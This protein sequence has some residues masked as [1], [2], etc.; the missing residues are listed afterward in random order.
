MGQ[1]IYLIS[2]VVYGKCMFCF[3][4]GRMIKTDDKEKK[5][6]ALLPLNKRVMH[7]FPS[8]MKTGAPKKMQLI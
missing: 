2:C 3:S 4:N 7:C 5:A 6:I 8:A 1:G